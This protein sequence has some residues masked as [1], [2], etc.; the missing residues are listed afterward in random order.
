MSLSNDVYS[1]F[2]ES[3]KAMEE[4]LL[5]CCDYLTPC[6]LGVDIMRS[7]TNPGERFSFGKSELCSSSSREQRSTASEIRSMSRLSQATRRVLPS[8]PSCEVQLSS[9]EAN[10]LTSPPSC[11]EQ[12]GSHE[13]E[14]S[15]E[16]YK[17]GLSSAQVT[18]RSNAGQAFILSLLSSGSAEE[19]ENH[20]FLLN[21][22][23]FELLPYQE[24]Q[25]DVDDLDLCGSCC[26]QSLAFS[27]IEGEGEGEGDM[28]PTTDSLLRLLQSSDGSCR[29]QPLVYSDDEEAGEGDMDPI[30]SDDEEKEEEDIAPAV[31]LFEILITSVDGNLGL[32]SQGNPLLELLTCA[33]QSHEEERRRRTRVYNAILASFEGGDFDVAWCE[34][35]NMMKL[36][37][38]SRS[39][40]SD[41][42]ESEEEDI[43]PAAY[44]FEIIISSVDSN[45][46]LASQGNPFLELSTCASQVTE[47]DS[48]QAYR[49]LSLQTP[50]SNGEALRS[51]FVPASPYRGIPP[52]SLKSQEE[53][54]RRRRTRVFN[55]ILASF[56]GGDFDVACSE[57]LNVTELP[58]PSG[59][60]HKSTSHGQLCEDTPVPLDSPSTHHSSFL[61]AAKTPAPVSSPTL[62]PTILDTPMNPN[63][64]QNPYAAHSAGQPLH[65]E[66]K[67]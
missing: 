10:V 66:S 29:F 26:F 8:P 60:L 25:T 12:L 28:D 36:P 3:D 55:D 14:V 41:N 63:E 34:F 42:E 35:L 31:N 21:A 2:M 65:K 61:N 46:E 17:L 47:Q 22:C 54:E 53:E 24:A 39:V 18:I 1:L 33:S 23:S 7:S 40:Y 64:S 38:L 16:G 43:A 52:S 58:S 4:A 57:L 5:A 9:Y 11:G 45:P 44:P 30:Y 13:V 48:Q 27:G 32:T 49:Y 6:L 19:E 56:E 59:S 20:S 37:S 62:L 15:G 67:S 51:I 50:V